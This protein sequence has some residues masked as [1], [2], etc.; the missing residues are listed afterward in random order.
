M[1]LRS[2]DLDPNSELYVEVDFRQLVL[3]TPL[4]SLGNLEDR[5]ERGLESAFTRPYFKSSELGASHE[6]QIRARADACTVQLTG[7]G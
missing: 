5:D 3:P 6:Q 2:D 4:S 1:S 7:A